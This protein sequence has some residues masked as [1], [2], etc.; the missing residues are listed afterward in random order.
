MGSLADNPIGARVAGA[1]APVPWRRLVEMW[2]PKQAVHARVGRHELIAWDASNLTDRGM[3][4]EFGW[5]LYTGPR[6]FDLVAKGAADS[7]AAAKQAAE[8]AYRASMAA[9]DGGSVIAI[10]KPA[11]RKITPKTHPRLFTPEAIQAL[12]DAAARLRADG[13]GDVAT[14]YERQAG[15]RAALAKAG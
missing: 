13:H 2:G 5:E 8:V 3:M 1:E 10:A 11:R 7:F 15:A 9:A 4:A 6:L 12:R 14:F